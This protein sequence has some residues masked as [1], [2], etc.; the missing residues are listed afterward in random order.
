[1]RPSSCSVRFGE[2][3]YAAE[4]RVLSNT[5]V[6]LI[7]FGLATFQD[8]S[9]SY[10]HSTPPY[11]APETWLCHEASFSHDIWS[12]GCTLV[13]FF[14]GDVLFETSDM[15]EYLAMIEAITGLRMEEEIAWITDAKFRG[16]LSALLPNAMQEPRKGVKKKKMKHIDVS[17]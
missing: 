8:E 10:F 16:I 15:L 1:L 3:R 14:T 7:D 12:I 13:E 9:P 2:G 6:R 5:E 4:R 11:S 17:D